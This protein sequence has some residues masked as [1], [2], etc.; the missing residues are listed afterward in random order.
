MMTEY[1]K[2]QFNYIRSIVLQHIHYPEEAQNRG[3][4]GKVLIS[5]VIMEDGNVK[6]LKVLTSSG[7]ALLDK[8]A[9][10]TVK[11]SAPFPKPPANA[12]LQLPITYVLET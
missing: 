8:N 12:E 4:E 5:F 6:D 1:F 7:Y 9:M 10:E 11:K 2:E 3:M